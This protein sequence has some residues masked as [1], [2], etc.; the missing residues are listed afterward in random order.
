[1]RGCQLTWVREQMAV[2]FGGFK[3]GVTVERCTQSEQIFDPAEE[4]RCERR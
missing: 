2:L 1:M 3:G 4:E